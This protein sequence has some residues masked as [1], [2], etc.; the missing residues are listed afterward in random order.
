LAKNLAACFFD[1]REEAVSQGDVQAPGRNQT[2]LK[3]FMLILALLMSGC[4]SLRGPFAPKPASRIDDPNLSISE[5]EVRGRD[6]IGLP[7]NTNP[8][9]PEAG[10]RPR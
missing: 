6:R 5:Q 1:I 4:E 8:L 7:D 10:Y 2:M 3:R 9:P